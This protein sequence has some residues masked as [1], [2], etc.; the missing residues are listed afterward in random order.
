MRNYLGYIIR[1]CKR[2]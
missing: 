1:P 2:K